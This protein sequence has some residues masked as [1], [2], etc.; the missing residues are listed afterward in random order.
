MCLQIKF[1]LATQYPRYY[2]DSGD[3]LSGTSHIG[4]QSLSLLD[5]T[6]ST[7]SG[8]LMFPPLGLA[9]ALFLRFPFDIGFIERFAHGVT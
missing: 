9:L 6:P 1:D 5:T 8:T 7:N 2:L 3:T 4:L